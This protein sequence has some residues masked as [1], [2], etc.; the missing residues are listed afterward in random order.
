MLSASRKGAKNP[1]RIQLISKTAWY[2][3]HESDAHNRPRVSGIKGARNREKIASLGTDVARELGACYSIQLGQEREEFSVFPVVDV[4]R[5]D[6]DQKARPKF[7]SVLL[8]TERSNRLKLSFVRSYVRINHR[9]YSHG[10]IEVEC[11]QAI[12]SLT[13]KR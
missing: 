6:K 4:V 1:R 11:E 7:E 10:N 8:W 2:A 12:W 13:M 3:R 9:G 5:R